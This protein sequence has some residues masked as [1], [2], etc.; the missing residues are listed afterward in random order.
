MGHIAVQEGRKMKTVVVYYSLTGNTDYTARE[1]AGILDADILRIEPRKEYPSEGLKKFLWGGRSAVMG[2]M[3]ELLPY[4]FD[5]EAYDKVVIGS[6]VWA[7]NPAPPMKTYIKE[8]LDLL[9]EKQVSAFLC[10][11]GGGADKAF[12]KLERMLGKDLCARMVLT[13][14][15]DVPDQDN[16]ARIREFCEKI[17]AQQRED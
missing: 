16:A 15:K 13:D 2:E 3:P 17:I 4:D 1:V 14:P 11:G 7:S 10:F 12:L 5:P 8:N 9:R 6:P